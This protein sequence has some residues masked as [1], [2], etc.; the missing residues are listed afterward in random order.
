[1]EC[2]NINLPNMDMDYFRVWL[3]N[4]GFEYQ[5]IPKEENWSAIKVFADAQGMNKVCEYINNLMDF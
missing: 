5:I 4:N 2:Y 3:I 1:M